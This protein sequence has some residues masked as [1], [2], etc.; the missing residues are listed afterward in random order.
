MSPVTAIIIMIIV[1]INRMTLI[2]QRPV[3]KRVEYTEEMRTIAWYH[4]RLRYFARVSDNATGGITG[5]L[6]IGGA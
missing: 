6:P 5:H 1:L 2:T 4:S 3:Q